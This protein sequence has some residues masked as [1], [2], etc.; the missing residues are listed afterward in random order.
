LAESASVGGIAEV[1]CRL[2]I[3]PYGH[4]PCVPAP[5]PIQSGVADSSNDASLAR[6]ERSASIPS[7]GFYGQRELALDYF[8]G[9]TA[10]SASVG[11]SESVA[12]TAFIFDSVFSAT[13]ASF[14]DDQ[15][16]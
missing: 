1:Y 10:S 11:F 12:S 9:A 13:P 5:D 8:L 2:R 15:T 4:N 3:F 6:L 16:Q 14:A 7:H